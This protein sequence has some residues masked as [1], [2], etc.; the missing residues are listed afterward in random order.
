MRDGID[1]MSPKDSNG[2]SAQHEEYAKEKAGYNVEGKGTA[3]S[4]AILENPLAGVSQEQ[5]IKDVEEFCCK[6]GLQD[7]LSSFIKGALI[8]Q[9]PRGAMS[10]PELTEEDREA[11]QREHTHKWSQPWML[12]FLTSTSYLSSCSFIRY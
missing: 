4:S 1:V 6:F 8:S 5:L 2:A 10:L 9:N 12:Y 7:N 11:L 3:T